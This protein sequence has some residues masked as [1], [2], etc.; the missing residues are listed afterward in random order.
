MKRI[1]LSVIAVAMIFGM[2]NIASASG[3]PIDVPAVG[4][5]LKTDALNFGGLPGLKVLATDNLAFEAYYVGLLGDFTGY[6][7][8]AMYLL[9]FELETGNLS[10]APYAGAGYTRIEQ[11]VKFGGATVQTYNGDYEAGLRGRG[12]VTCKGSGIQ[13]FG[14]VQTNPFQTL[15]NLF[16]EAELILSL[17]NVEGEAKL[18]YRG[19]GRLEGH[20]TEARSKVEADYSSIGLVLGVTYYF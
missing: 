15:P 4:V 18:E 16:L 12:Q 11:K 9:P 19:T 14:G 10:L 3:Q 8:R 17:F 6:S 2:A 7:F 1:F 20:T 13:L 5:T